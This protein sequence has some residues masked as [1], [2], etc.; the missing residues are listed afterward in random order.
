MYE[1]PV[2]NLARSLTEKLSARAPVKAFNKLPEG[3]VDLFISHCA[4]LFSIKNIRQNTKTAEL[5]NILEI[6]TEKLNENTDILLYLIGNLTD[7]DIKLHQTLEDDTPWK[8]AKSYNA[9]LHEICELNNLENI[10]KPYEKK[11]LLIPVKHVN[12]IVI[13]D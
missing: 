13:K 1:N 10:L 5:Q 9:E 12:E 8:L 3:L 11:L 2:S 4:L 6:M 7:R